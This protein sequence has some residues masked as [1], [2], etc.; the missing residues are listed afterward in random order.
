MY[1]PSSL[2]VDPSDRQ[3]D[4][5]VGLR[6][7]KGVWPSSH[8]TRSGQSSSEARA[9][10]VR[11]SS[12]GHLRESD[13]EPDAHVRNAVHEIPHHAKLSDHT[14][15][16]E[17]HQEAGD[18]RRKRRRLVILND[19][20]GHMRLTH[21]AHEHRCRVREDVDASDDAID[22]K[23][24]DSRLGAMNSNLRHGAFVNSLAECAYLPLCTVN[25]QSVGR[26]LFGKAR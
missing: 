5:A 14:D 2:G 24:L 26:Q 12:C 22:I 13:V 21:V 11:S 9:F 8:A 20:E 25:A 6:C 17:R 18:E 10:V 7:A 19:N 1:R 23:H 4:V 16:Q 15:D 3:V